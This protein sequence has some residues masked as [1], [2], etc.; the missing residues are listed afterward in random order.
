MWERTSAEPNLV[1]LRSYLVDSMQD[2]KGTATLSAKARGKQK[3]INKEIKLSDS[4]YAVPHIVYGSVG[5]ESDDDASMTDGEC[6]SMPVVSPRKKKA[7]AAPTPLSSQQEQL[8]VRDH[9]SRK[10]PVEVKQEAGASGRVV[11]ARITADV[12]LTEETGAEELDDDEGI[13]TSEW[14][15]R[16]G[17]THEL[18]QL[19]R[20]SGLRVV[21]VP[22]DGAC[23]V[24]AVLLL[25]GAAL[26]LLSWAATVVA[27]GDFE[28][29]VASDEFEHDNQPLVG[30]AE[31]R[32]MQLRALMRALRGQVVDWLLLHRGDHGMRGHAGSKKQIK[33]FRGG[34]S[35]GSGPV[36][37][38]DKQWTQAHHLR[39]MAAVLGVD[40]ASLHVSAGEP[41]PDRVNVYGGADG[42]PMRR[43]LSWEDEI[44]PR[45]AAQRAPGFAG[46]RLLVLAWNGRDH[47]DA[48][49]P[50]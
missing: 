31:G 34:E 35:D 18:A 37:S 20:A 16:D 15:A 27:P 48:L 28:R 11:R 44:A 50:D 24:W 49:L 25:M 7:R 6:S 43:P 19:L 32:K 46:R 47:F 33:L 29:V 4:K 45:L 12:R 36:G 39:A 3:Q 1:N 5:A 13:F 9:S 30:Q 21:R 10:R 14:M 26:P 42:E 17:R 40:I 23:G 22:P 2:R 41:V 8:S 38:G